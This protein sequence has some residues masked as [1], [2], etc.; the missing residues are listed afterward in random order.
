MSAWSI[1]LDRTCDAVDCIIDGL[2][3]AIAKNYTD[4]EW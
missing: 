3:S 2:E 1:L 4:E